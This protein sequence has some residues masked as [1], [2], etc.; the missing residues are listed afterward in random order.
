MN[1]VWYLETATELD[2]YRSKKAKFFRLI[3]EMPTWRAL[4]VAEPLLNWYDD[5]FGTAEYHTSSVLRA[6][7]LR[8]TEVDD[9]D[10]L[11]SLN[12]FLT[13]VYEVILGALTGSQVVYS[14]GGSPRWLVPVNNSDQPRSCR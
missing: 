5:Q 2:I 12:M 1:A 4:L 9:N 6:T 11:D 13:G 3:R 10:L 7:L 14:L 8:G